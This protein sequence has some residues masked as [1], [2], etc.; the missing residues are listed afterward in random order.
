MTAY[1][2]P[3]TYNLRVAGEVAKQV[4]I[5][6]RL[7]PPTSV[8]EVQAITSQAWAQASQPSFWTN[9][10]QSGQWPNGCYFHQQ[11]R[12]TVMKEGRVLCTWQRLWGE[13]R[14]V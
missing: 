5:A 4:Y 13:L 11:H 12:L 7:A 6:E 8:A 2:E 1:K 3:V 9:L 10:I 14:Y